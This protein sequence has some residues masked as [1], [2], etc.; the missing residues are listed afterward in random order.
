MMVVVAY[1]RMMSKVGQCVVSKKLTNEERPPLSL[2][3]TF[4]R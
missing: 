3:D 1:S 2:Y 4:W